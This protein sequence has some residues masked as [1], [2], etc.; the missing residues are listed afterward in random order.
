MENRGVPSL[1]I[2]MDWKDGNLPLSNI[3]LFDCII[4]TFRKHVFVK[5]K[6]DMLYNHIVSSL[7]SHDGTVVSLYGGIRLL[8]L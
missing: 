2:Q 6:I 1:H 3:P 7:Y 4:T 5:E 8:V